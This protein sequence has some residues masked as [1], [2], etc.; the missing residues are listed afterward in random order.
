MGV[1]HSLYTS[2]ELG[3]IQKT[4][5]LSLTCHLSNS[6]NILFER[7]IAQEMR[8]A[9]SSLCT[10]YAAAR[11]LVTFHCLLLVE[12]IRGL[13]ERVERECILKKIAGILWHAST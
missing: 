4:L 11:D 2:T 1:R 9:H 12:I 5:F 10:F 6:C 7:Q 8:S 13:V 3:A